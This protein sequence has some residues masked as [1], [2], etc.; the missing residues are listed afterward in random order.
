LSEDGLPCQSEGR[1]HYNQS[2][3]VQR[4]SSA[5]THAIISAPEAGMSAMAA[6]REIIIVSF[7]VV[8]FSI[9][10]QGLTM[11]WLI[12]RFRLIGSRGQEDVERRS[13]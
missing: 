3:L 10:V 1:E 13:D 5:S 4:Q 7:G 11:P 9:F 2:R 8:A 6:R 12:Q